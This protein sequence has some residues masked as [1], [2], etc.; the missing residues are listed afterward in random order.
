MFIFNKINIKHC[1]KHCF[2]FTD[3]APLDDENDQL[4]YVRE[5]VA[6]KFQEANGWIDTESQQ[7]SRDE[8]VAKTKRIVDL[9]APKFKTSDDRY[10][11]FSQ[12]RRLDIQ[13]LGL[14]S[15]IGDTR[16]N[17][18]RKKDEN[19]TR[20][21]K[22]ETEKDKRISTFTVQAGPSVNIKGELNT[23]NLENIHISPDP[24]FVQENPNVGTYMICH[25]FCKKN[26]GFSPGKKEKVVRISD[27]SNSKN[28]MRSTNGKSKKGSSKDEDEIS[29]EISDKL[30]R[31]DIASKEC[32]GVFVESDEKLMEN[33]TEESLM[34]NLE[35]KENL[36]STMNLKLTQSINDKSIQKV[37]N[38]KPDNEAVKKEAITEHNSKITFKNEQK[39]IRFDEQ[40]SKP[41]RNREK[42]KE[43]CSNLRQDSTLTRILE[44]N[45]EKLKYSLSLADSKINDELPL[46]SNII[47]EIYK[48]NKKRHKEICEKRKTE[49]EEERYKE[50]DKRFSS[51]VKK[52][53][54]K[55]EKVE[56]SKIDNENSSH[57][58]SPSIISSEDSEG[59]DELYTLYEPAVDELDGVLSSYNKIIDNIVRSTKTIDKFLS[60]PELEE[61]QVD[62]TTR[63]KTSK[64]LIE[65]VSLGEEKTYKKRKCSAQSR[66]KQGTKIKTVKDRLP[67]TNK[68]INKEWDVN[69]MK[70][71]KG[72]I[73]TKKD[74]DSKKK[75]TAPKI[76]NKFP[77]RLNSLMKDGSSVWKEFPQQEETSESN[78]DISKDGKTIGINASKQIPRHKTHLFRI[79]NDSSNLTTSSNYPQSSSIDMKNGDDTRITEEM[80][81]SLT[82]ND[83]IREKTTILKINSLKVDQDNEVQ[84]ENFETLQNIVCPGILK[85]ESRGSKNLIAR[86]LC[87]ETRLIEDKIKNIFNVNEIVPLIVKN[88]T[89]NLKS[90][91]TNLKLL[92]VE[93]SNNVGSNRNQ[94][95]QIV[96]ERES[97]DEKMR[98]TEKQDLQLERLPSEGNFSAA[99]TIKYNGEIMGENILN[100]S[101]G[102]YSILIESIPNSEDELK[103]NQ[104]ISQ[105][106][107]ENTRDEEVDKIN[108]NIDL[109]KSAET[110]NN[111]SKRN[112]ENIISK[113]IDIQRKEINSENL[114]ST[115]TVSNIV[116]ESNENKKYNAMY[117]NEKI[118]LHNEDT[119]LNG[120]NKISLITNDEKT[121]NVKHNDFEISD[122]NP[123]LKKEK[124]VE[125]YS[126]KDAEKNDK[127]FDNNFSQASSSNSLR[128]FISFRSSSRNLSR[129]SSNN[130]EF[131]QDINE[132]GHIRESSV[133][134]DNKIRNNLLYNL[135]EK[136]KILSNVY[137]D[138]DKKFSST[139]I[140]TNYSSLL[141][142]EYR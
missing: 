134:I 19:R 90:D 6:F 67:A 135:L 44:D 118:N 39:Q 27:D 78:E 14:S 131:S 25:D 69:K 37:S 123:D 141:N 91:E 66:S 60:R 72:T 43:I 126:I 76:S 142:Q 79:V 56:K 113:D 58:L 52:Y 102:K 18:E 120:I 2:R 109:K 53:C 140:D 104:S 112:N 45:N 32:P 36:E 119:N 130:P 95:A 124:S 81:K 128:N 17:N 12:Q 98:K 125:L 68:N 34:K 11:E 64:K 122:K 129:T 41:N 29:A 110:D 55:D 40:A 89:E 127:Q 61:Y 137:D 33:K 97:N 22:H 13:K 106:K 94:I 77:T 46:S 132:L 84:K 57:V 65:P 86:V 3:E 100:K 83:E 108:F 4:L 115:K 42:E 62:D 73:F 103:R 59:S 15:F 116:N 23:Q 21:S 28:N 121:E 7:S 71:V 10:K 20:S 31:I 24:S 35:N 82:I 1:I 75:Y 114:I 139:Y 88:L 101:D 30:E 80:S 85:Q 133:A 111:I 70:R 92:I 48:I 93:D 54:E 117:V 38:L 16:G 47:E 63:M 107:N 50:I 5:R 26:D 87:E 136:K 74:H 99:E 96:E 105:S 9:S 138:L 51:I 8:L 49:N